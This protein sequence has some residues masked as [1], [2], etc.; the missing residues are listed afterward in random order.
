MTA[1][2]CAFSQ[3]CRTQ[4]QGGLLCLGLSVC[5]FLFHSKQGQFPF[6]FSCAGYH[7]LIPG[8][9]LH[10]SMNSG[11]SL[12]AVGW[13]GCF[14]MLVIPGVSIISSPAWDQLRGGWDPAASE[15]WL[16]SPQNPPQ[17][18]LRL[19]VYNLNTRKAQIN[20]ISC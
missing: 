19:L 15:G 20:P 18:L 11:S 16:S 8:C 2:H 3:H 12:C 7:S 10:D 9:S 6:T 13:E 4:T 17:F 5:S 1:L 14:G